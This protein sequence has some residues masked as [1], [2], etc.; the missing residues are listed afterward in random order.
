MAGLTG[1]VSDEFSQ[2]SSA[3][4]PPASATA[5]IAQVNATTPT[6]DV[7]PEVI[8]PRPEA[9]PVPIPVT[10]APPRLSPGVDEVVQLA[11]TQIGDE[12]LLAYID[13]SPARFELDI[14]Q[15]LYL[16]DLG[17]SAQVIAAMVRHNQDLEVSDTLA[18]EP[19][20]SSATSL[21]GVDPAPAL[22]PLPM[23]ETDVYAAPTAVAVSTEASQQTV[24]HH[25]FHTALAPY[26]TWVEVPDYGWSW[27]PT[28]AVIDPNWRPY[29]HGGRWIHTDYGWYWHSYYSWGWAPFHYGRWHLSPVSGW[30][31]I[32]D[33]RWGP[34]W[35]TWRYYDG[36][37]GWAPL[38]P[39]AIYTSGIGL[40]YHGRHVSYG[41][42][43]GLGASWF[44]FVPAR[45]FHTA[46]PWHHCV[47]HSRVTRI[48]DNSTVINNY[49]VGD[50]NTTI[51]NVGP[52]TETI[53]AAARTEI[54]KVQ[55][56]D[57]NPG[58][59]RTI[60]AESLSRDGTTLAAYRPQLP[61]QASAPPPEITRRQ[62]ELQRRA[63]TIAS[64]DAAQTATIQARQPSPTLGRQITGAS[65]NQPRPTSA[66]RVV[67]VEPDPSS[68]RP[69]AAPIS[70]QTSRPAAARVEPQTR[71]AVPQTPTTSGTIRAGRVIQQTPAANPTARPSIPLRPEA[72]AVPTA[73]RTAEPRRTVTPQP[74]AATRTE[75]RPSRI[76][77]TR[78]VPVA[79]SIP[80]QGT[81][82]EPVRPANPSYSVSSQAPVNSQLRP[83]QLPRFETPARRSFS[84]PAPATSIPNRA[85]V[86]RSAID[87]TPRQIAPARPAPSPAP[88]VRSTPTIQPRSI[89]PSP[90]RPSAPSPAPAR[91]QS[92][93][94]QPARGAGSR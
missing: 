74:P 48:Y 47:P 84:Q 38:P 33:T 29:V 49:V 25:H 10:T 44:S 78:P 2:V 54:Q 46:R 19:I 1:C 82:V 94:P 80:N 28:V 83:V 16:H 53:A 9:G 17:L 52:G 57:V 41:F 70:P 8:P 50:N 21:T 7:R 51:I 34:A 72:A 67:R 27:R 85:I 15:I 5:P 63:E 69:S 36:Y 45:H 20:P 61:E 23:S 73:P 68:R 79:P 42:S 71:P 18:Q 77:P 26:G 58:P 92:A 4:I 60:R 89:N 37:Y 3:G 66:P 86:P 13:N 75:P 81:R 32:P 55:I 88:A 35:V 59:T 6:A 22:E 11:Q 30:V 31:W 90:A 12:V 64:S 87:L 56:Q 39:R 76:Q 93:P 24:T 65:V 14:H 43:F 40:T 62:A 91:P